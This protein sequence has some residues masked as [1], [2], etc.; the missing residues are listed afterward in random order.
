MHSSLSEDFTCL[1]IRQEKIGWLCLTRSSLSGP[2]CG[3]TSP[4]KRN[5]YNSC[6]DILTRL[7]SIGYFI[8]PFFVTVERGTWSVN[9]QVPA[10]P[11]PL[12]FRHVQIWL[13][14]VSY[15]Y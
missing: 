11:V 15:F 2:Y 14:A 8:F 3:I 5:I 10:F 6:V 1:A 12:V 7:Y 9:L 4:R 13:V